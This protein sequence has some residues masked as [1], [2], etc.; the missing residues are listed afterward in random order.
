MN[1]GDFDGDDVE[2]V[3]ESNEHDDISDLLRDL[4]VGLD[5]RGDYEENSSVPDPCEELVA[6]QNLVAEN[7]K[8]LYLTCKKYTQL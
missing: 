3:D 1:H 5:D 2:V 6:I 7:N 8:E 4:A